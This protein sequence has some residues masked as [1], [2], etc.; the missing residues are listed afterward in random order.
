M[1][2]DCDC[3]DWTPVR[4]LLDEIPHK[5]D[6]YHATFRA[7]STLYRLEW[8]DFSAPPANQDGATWWSTYEALAL[9]SAYPGATY[10]AETLLLAHARLIQDVV[11]NE[12]KKRGLFQ[13]ER[14]AV[15]PADG[16]LKQADQGGAE[17]YQEALLAVHEELLHLPDFT[18][19]ETQYDDPNDGPDITDLLAAHIYAIAKK[20]A[21]NAMKRLLRQ[22]RRKQVKWPRYEIKPKRFDELPPEKEIEEKR[23]HAKAMQV[24][25]GSLQDDT[26]RQIAEM[27]ELRM[28]DEAIAAQLGMRTH[29]VN[30][31]WH[32]M[33]NRMEEKLGLMP[34]KIIRR[35]KRKPD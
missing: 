16:T 1:S 23:L 5:R 34:V 32:R 3:Y 30:R 20:A 2:T 8:L 18:R 17:I 9:L 35:A 14:F 24:V 15:T 26:E 31:M 12:L 21:E 19:D 33:L 27:K 13:Q 25:D 11:M 4:K 10:P 28:S 22:R 7:G 29:K 6:I